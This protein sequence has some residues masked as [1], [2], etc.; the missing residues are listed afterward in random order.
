MSE[1]YRLVTIGV[2]HYCEKARWA[3]DRLGVPYVEEPHPPAFHVPAAWRLG[4]RRTVP[5]LVTPGSALADSTDI[6]L[7]LDRAIAPPPARLYPEEPSLRSEVLALEDELDEVLGPHVRR[8]AYFHLLEHPQLL[9]LVTAR[10]PTHERVL[11]RLTIPLAKLLMRRSLR[12]DA[13][14]A[15]R[16]LQRIHEVFARIDARLSDGRRSLCGDRFSAADL[17]LAALSAP[18][19][20]PPEYVV[21]GAS[22]PPLDELPQAFRAENERLRAR[23]AG[24]LVLSLYREQRRRVE[25]AL[26]PT[27]APTKA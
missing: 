1:P 26:A 14:G 15:A 7:F 11:L 22:L 16:S 21:P 18:L 2:S 9:E 4:G 5:V 19:L 8:F 20:M 23:P 27:L 10:V 12:I 24:Q 3:L 17:T 13:A 6:L 25:P